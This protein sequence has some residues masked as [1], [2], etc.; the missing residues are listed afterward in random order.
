MLAT[1]SREEALTP[2]SQLVWVEGME[3]GC[4]HLIKFGCRAG[5]KA[6]MD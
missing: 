5:W 6:S 4:H 3:G 1:D 2:E